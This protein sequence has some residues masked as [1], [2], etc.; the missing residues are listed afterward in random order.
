MV[1]DRSSPTITGWMRASCGPLAARTP[2]LSAPEVRRRRQRYETDTNQPRRC[3]RA[4]GRQR[5]RRRPRGSRHRTLR[6]IA[7]LAEQRDDADASLVEAIREA[8]AAGR[9][10]SMIAAKLGV[11]E[12]AARRDIRT[13]SRDV[14][15]VGAAGESSE[16][17]AE[18]DAG[19]LDHGFSHEF[20]MVSP[21]P[22]GEW[23]GEFTMAGLVAV[24]RGRRRRGSCGPGRPCDRSPSSSRCRAL[25]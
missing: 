13:Q 25:W 15:S 20:G 3:G 14:A 9:S 11:S 16:S 7:E 2:V 10:W 5:L 12:Q 8:L 6:A 22:L 19:S 17:D 24:V 21:H 23:G 1:R 18:V 4:V